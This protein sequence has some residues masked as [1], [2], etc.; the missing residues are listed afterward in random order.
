MIAHLGR[1]KDSLIKAPGILERMHAQGLTRG[2]VI[3]A[4]KVDVKIRD[5]TLPEKKLFREGD[6]GIGKEGSFLGLMSSI[7]QANL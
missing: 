1:E 6:G 4:F 3:W 2:V 5:I 7:G